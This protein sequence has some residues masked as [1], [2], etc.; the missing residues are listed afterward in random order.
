MD[1]LARGET[2]TVLIDGKQAVRFH[3]PQK[4]YT[5]GHIVLQ[6]MAGTVRFRKVEISEFGVRR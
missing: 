6:V 3:D 4:S 2:I 5:S 1:I